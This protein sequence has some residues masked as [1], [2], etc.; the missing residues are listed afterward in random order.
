[1][2]HNDLIQ[3]HEPRRTLPRLFVTRTLL[4]GE[5]DCNRRT[6]YRG[7]DSLPI[8][9]QE[10]SRDGWSRDDAAKL[11]TEFDRLAAMSDEDLAAVPS[12]F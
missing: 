9:R 12:L 1:M 5:P 6:I 2:S 10:A 7:S 11:K 4:S 3:W 8:H